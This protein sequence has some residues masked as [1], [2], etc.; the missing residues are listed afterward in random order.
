[1]GGTVRLAAIACA[2]ALAAAAGAQETPQFTEAEWRELVRGKTLIYREDGVFEGLERYAPAGNRVEWQ[3]PNGDCTIGT[4]EV[5]EEM[6]CFNW[7]RLDVQ[8]Y[9]HLRVGERVIVVGTELSP[10]PGE[11]TEVTEIKELP[12]SCGMP[13]S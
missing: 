4:W 10:S 8:C 1:M 13:M 5:V 11:V 7:E 9:R 12:I 6:F 3:Y 2:L